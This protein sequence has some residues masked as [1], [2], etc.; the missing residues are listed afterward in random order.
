MT[1]EEIALLLGFIIVISAI[2]IGVTGHYVSWWLGCANIAGVVGI[3][4]SGYAIGR[5]NSK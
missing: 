5:L 2:A 1:T 3:G 4:I